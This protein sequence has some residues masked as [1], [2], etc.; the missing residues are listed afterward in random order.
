MPISDWFRARES[1]RYTPARPPEDR[2]KAA[3][4]S[5]VKCDDCRT[6]VYEGELEASLRVCPN[7]GHHFP[8]P[9]VERVRQL[10]DKDSFAEID[11]DVSSA[12][13]L[14]FDCGKPYQ[15][16]MARAKERTGLAEA[17]VT[18]RATVSGRPVVVGAMDFRFVGA[19]MGS[20]VG[21]KVARAFELAADEDRAVV[22]TTSSGGA[23]MQ[24][25]ILSL[26]QMAKTSAAVAR[27]AEMRLPY[28]SILTNPTMGGV[29][30]SF[31]VLAD[32][33]LAEPG[34]LVGF[35]G[36]RVIE[37]TLK[38]KLPKDFQ[39]SEFLL[40][41]GMV[42]AVVH[43]KEMRETVARLL[44]YLGAAGDGDGP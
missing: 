39:T 31:A 10:V 1:R 28:V 25:G 6:I 16:T 20:A 22:F 24:E 26:M 4:G 34:A 21:E 40:E 33:I 37:Q 35:T 42:D 15:E 13:P 18:G 9:A 29:T 19:S 11:A 8:M 38:Q 5:W 44:G 12:D 27:L 36:P 23:R 32:V 30:A 43:R 3:E 14:D 41:H 17:I 7:C 2:S